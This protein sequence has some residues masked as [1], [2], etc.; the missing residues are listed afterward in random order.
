M[1]LSIGAC[2]KC[3][4]RGWSPAKNDL[5]VYIYGLKVECECVLE[6]KTEEFPE[7]RDDQWDNLEPLPRAE[8]DEC[9]YQNR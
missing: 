3:G 8:P 6:P 1:Q 5:E 2:T 7:Y 9:F 4:G